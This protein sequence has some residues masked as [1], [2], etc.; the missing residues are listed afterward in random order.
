M[1]FEVSR[2][3]RSLMCVVM[4]AAAVVIASAFP[5]VSSNLPDGSDWKLCM[6]ATQDV[7]SRI[8]ACSRLVS[9]ADTPLLAALQH[10]TKAE[11]SQIRL[12]RAQAYLDSDDRGNYASA[13]DDYKTILQER[14]DPAEALMGLGVAYA[15]LG[16]IALAESAFGEAAKVHPS[17]P[18][19][20][21]LQTTLMLLR[22]PRPEVR[23]RGPAV[24]KNIF[25]GELVPSLPP[26]SIK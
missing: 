11:I 10:L 2:T 26:S 24:L 23:R 25:A 19:P 13:I 1:G 3:P 17:D 20:V 16:N 15:L 5:A 12:A 9:I 21:L 18:K 4:T 8:Q 22:D 14:G 6:S 7:P